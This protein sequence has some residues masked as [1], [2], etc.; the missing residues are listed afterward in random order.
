MAWFASHIVFIITSFILLHNA[1]TKTGLLSFFWQDLLGLLRNLHQSS[2]S[3]GSQRLFKKI[4]L[5]L[6]FNY[7][8]LIILLQLSQ[9]ILFC[10][11]PS[12]IPHSLRQFPH[13]CSCT[14]VMSLSALGMYSYPYGCPVLLNS[15]TSSPIPHIPLISGNHQTDLH[16]DDSDSVLFVCLVY[17]LD[18]I[19]DSYVFAIL[20]FI[21][22]I[23]FFLLNKSLQYFI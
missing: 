11:S 22:L 20:L 19:V 5:F 1:I 8:L 15:L 9:F 16:I 23:F 3:I 12:S 4:Y 7:I 17:F 6:F 14:W 13:H 18:S 10:S 21:V 2:P